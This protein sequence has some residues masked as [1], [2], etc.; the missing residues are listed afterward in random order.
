MM[1]KLPRARAEPNRRATV[2]LELGSFSPLSKGDSGLRGDEA[3]GSCH[4]SFCLGHESKPQGSAM[5]LLWTVNLLPC[6]LVARVRDTGQERNVLCTFIQYTGTPVRGISWPYTH[7][8]T[9]LLPPSHPSPFLPS[10]CARTNLARPAVTDLHLGEKEASILY[11]YFFG[12][13]PPDDGRTE[14]G[15]SIPPSSV[16][17]FLLLLPVHRSFFDSKDREID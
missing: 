1:R 11:V 16:P 14:L 7:R 3:G 4:I 17:P 13:E 2:K 10:S 9:L 15:W 12:Y 6:L 8:A 5:M